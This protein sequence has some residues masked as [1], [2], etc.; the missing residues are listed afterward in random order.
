[1]AGTARI[2]KQSYSNFLADWTSR[3]NQPVRTCDD[4]LHILPSCRVEL[5]S[6]VLDVIQTLQF[7]VHKSQVRKQC[8]C[9][10]AG[11]HFGC[12]L[13]VVEKASAAMSAARL[14]A[15]DIKGH[16]PHSIRQ[17]SFHPLHPAHHTGTVLAARVLNDSTPRGVG[18]AVR[19]TTLILPKVN[20]IRKHSGFHGN[21]QNPLL[22]NS[23]LAA[24]GCTVNLQVLRSAALCELR[25]HMLLQA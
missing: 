15:W 12:N 19:A 7:R 13:M 6:D 9:N 17:R 22:R 24:R 8:A 3:T 4:S 11:R 25:V 2:C 16:V 23:L 10:W 1:M 14:N 20:D 21:A 18:L 5:A